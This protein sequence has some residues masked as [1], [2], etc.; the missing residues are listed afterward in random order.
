MFSIS[1]IKDKVKKYGL[2]LVLPEAN[3]IR[4]L[5]AAEIIT[6]EKLV[7]KLVLLGNPDDI[8]SKAK[9]EGIS[10]SGIEILDYLHSPDLNKFADSYY[11]MRKS[12]GISQ[13]EALEA[14][15]DPICYSMF[16]V[17][18]GQVST[19]VCGSIATT[20]N[21]LRAAIHVIGMD[22]RSR[23]ISSC[24]LM[25]VP[26]CDYGNDGALL[27]ADAGAVPNPSAEQLADIA[28]NSEKTAKSIFSREPKIAML[29]FSTRGS[30]KHRMIE[31]VIKATDIV[32]QKEPDLLI[33]GE[34][35]ADSAIVP[36][37]A[38]R[39]LSDSPVA[40]SANVLIFPDLNSGNICYKLVQRLAKAKAYG[41]M[42]QGLKIPVS[43]LSRG[44]N[45]EDIVNT[46]V[47][48]LLRIG[49]NR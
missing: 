26:D 12:K 11:E 40:G 31:K 49:A 10:L 2:S 43:D 4:V 28:I 32:L 15:Q 33:D 27:F 42:I 29:S 45:V 1:P 46:S 44:C 16:M 36:E 23:T 41:P 5:K 18:E 3:D 35:Q 13:E 38:K 8:N 25:I 37:V 39:K 22:D 7:K 9:Q 24:F 30:A 20:A 21:V 47:L 14:V 17:K 6:K 19:A 48:T 34:L